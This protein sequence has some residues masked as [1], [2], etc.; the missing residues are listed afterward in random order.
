MPVTEKYYTEKQ[1][2]DEYSLLSFKD[3]CDILMIALDYMQQYNNR[4]KF[5]CIAMAMGYKNTEGEK[6][7]YTK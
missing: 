6:N 7:T 4:T 1:I 5:L 2:S 3:R